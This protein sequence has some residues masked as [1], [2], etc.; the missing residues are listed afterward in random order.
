MTGLDGPWAARARVT[1]CRMWKGPVMEDRGARERAILERMVQAL[2]GGDEL[3]ITEEG[4]ADRVLIPAPPEQSRTRP[5]AE[6]QRFEAMYYRLDPFPSVSDEALT[7][8]LVETVIRLPENVREYVCNEC[9]FVEVDYVR[10]IPGAQRVQ[11]VILLSPNMPADHVHSLI[12][13][14]IALVWLQR[15]HPTRPCTLGLDLAAAK[16]VQRWG[17]EGQGAD[18]EVAQQLVNDYGA[19]TGYMNL[20]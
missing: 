20:L 5:T 4:E 1:E 14:E 3:L 13:H 2:S 9:R 12:A 16:L 15:R 8:A 7:R 10:T 11:W 18:V 19:A 6:Q 17:F